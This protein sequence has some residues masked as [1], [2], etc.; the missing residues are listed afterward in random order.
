MQP[1]TLERQAFNSK[2]AAVKVGVSE[3]TLLRL[4]REGHLRSVR[5]CRRHIISQQSI[6]AFLSGEGQSAASTKSGR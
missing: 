2:E 4:I 6:D 5:V 1:A 3:S